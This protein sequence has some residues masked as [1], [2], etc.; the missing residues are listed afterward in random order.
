[1]PRVFVDGDNNFRVLHAGHVL[2]RAGD[3][4]GDVKFRGDHL[5][6]L[7]DLQRVRGDPGVHQRARRANGPAS[8]SAN[9]P[10]NRSKSSAFLIAR[11]PETTTRAS[12]ESGRP[13][14]FA[15]RATYSICDGSLVASMATGRTGEAA[16]VLA[17]GAKAA[18]RTVKNFKGP[19]SFT[20]AMTLP[21][22]MTRL[23]TKSV[24]SGRTSITSLI[25]PASSNAAARGR[26]SLLY[27]DAAPTTRVAFCARTTS[28]M[29]LG[30]FIR[31][32]FLK[33]WV[34]RD[35]HGDGAVTAQS[36]RRGGE[37]CCP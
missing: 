20:V 27:V 36:F 26:M 22:Y 30:I 19:S 24:P 29:T 16:V 7:P 25:M 17:G 5:A 23:K 15:S 31:E 2:N 13:A 10:I 14:T 11:P 37:P 3:A 35:Q 6:G 33:G 32:W 34:I 28:S 4:D 9:P 21:A 1:V 12:V 18:E 8:A